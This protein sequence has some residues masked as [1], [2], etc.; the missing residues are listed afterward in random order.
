[1]M[2]LFV[3]IVKRCLYFISIILENTEIIVSDPRN[4]PKQKLLIDIL[5][6]NQL[7]DL[8]LCITVWKY[9]MK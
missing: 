9:R 8:L 2:E 7:W 3:K 6:M 4:R 5:L 1:M